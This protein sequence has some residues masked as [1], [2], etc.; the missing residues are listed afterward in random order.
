LLLTASLSLYTLPSHIPSYT[1]Y[2]HLFQELSPE[3]RD[4]DV[5]YTNH[6]ADDTYLEDQ[7]N[8][9]LPPELLA[10]RVT[11]VEEAQAARR[12]WYLTDS[13]YEDSVQAAFHELEATHRLWGVFGQCKSEW[14]YVA[15]LMVAPPMREAVFF[16]ETIG[17][18]GAD[19]S[20]VNQNQL[21]VL[22]W[23]T[24][25]EQPQTDYS[26]SLQLIYPDGSLASQVDRQI[27]PPEAEIGE[28]PTSQLQPNGNYLDWRVLD[29]ANLPNGDYRLQLV[30]YQWQDGV[31]L[32]LPDGSDAYF[33]E[34]IS[35]R[36]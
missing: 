35:L 12:V 32:S 8:R 16:G 17:F 20:S 13:L 24:V 18:L 11:T 31:R 29:L 26:I 28:I 7:L 4:G 33:I 22:L 15:Q 34:N 21:P 9:Y 6:T 25:E 14:C 1:P 36:R 27:D 2:R 23:W 30:V 10:N 3:V 19:I 5:L